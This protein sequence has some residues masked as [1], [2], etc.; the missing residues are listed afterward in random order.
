MTTSPG[1]VLVLVDHPN[2]D[3][4]LLP[5]VVEL[6]ARGHHVDPL[7]VE[8]GRSERFHAAGLLPLTDPEAFSAFLATPG[9]RLFVTGADQIPQHALGVR[10]ELLCRAQGIPSLALEH[11]PFSLGH[12][13]GFPPHLA[14][15]ADVMALIG[16]EDERRFATLG[17]DPRRLVVTGSPAFDRL[18]VEREAGA[19]AAAAGT[20]VVIFGQGHT[21]VGPHSAQRLDPGAWLPAMER[22]YRTLA[23]CFP[24]APIRVKPHPAE[25]AHR[26]DTLYLEAVPPELSGRVEVLPTDSDN[27]SLILDSALVLSFSSSVWLEA[28]LLGRAAV[29]FPLQAR[30]GRTAADIEAMGGLWLPGRAPDFAARLEP[31]LDRLAVAASAPASPA[32]L[33][34]YSGPVDGCACARVADLAERLLRE[35]PPEVVRP[36][37]VFDD[38]GAR[39]R[40]LH[41][42]V[43]YADYV[44]LQALA[45]EVMGAG[46]EQPVVLEVGPGPSGLEAHLPLAFHS[47]HAGLLAGGAPVVPR[48]GYF[49]VVVAPDLWGDGLPSNLA[50][51]LASMVALA[52]RRVVFSLVAEAIDEL[53]RSLADLLPEGAPLRPLPRCRPPVDLLTTLCRATGAQVQVRQIHN[54]ASYVQALL[55]EHL[56]LDDPSLQAVRRTLQ[57]VAY[58]HEK[59]EGGVRLVFTLNRQA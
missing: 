59:R 53:H 54:G 1:R 3:L 19:R 10:C 32:V 33:E 12:D 26:T 6:A 4:L 58:G 49:D 39:P 35:G 21:W 8:H 25:P 52:R 38:P 16:S 22:L 44:H 30:S 17:I 50:L 36:D 20:G 29:F 31:H 18:A 40:L 9:P 28:R 13:D 51:E 41:T 57:A 15:G 45:D 23:A 24:G 5:V 2:L 43:G 34:P 37:L 56:G 27:V 14:F 46:V 7:V 48:Y 11:A 55:L 47:R 42:Q